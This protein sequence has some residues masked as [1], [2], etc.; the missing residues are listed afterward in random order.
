[1]SFNNN[2]ILLPLRSPLLFELYYICNVLF[3]IIYLSFFG[4]KI[5]DKKIKK[6]FY[7]IN[8]FK[9]LNKSISNLRLYYQFNKIL[10]YYKPKTVITT[11]EGHAWE[12]LFIIF[13]IKN[14]K[15][16]GYQFSILIKTSFNI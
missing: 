2:K 11:F 3:Y 13:V 1:M 15:T 10:K 9:I 16:I 14:I 8:K 5:K 4:F 7:N 12:K 6:I